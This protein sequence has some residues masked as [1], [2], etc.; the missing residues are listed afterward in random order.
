MQ[1]VDNFLIVNLGGKERHIDWYT[2]Y[3]K[4]DILFFLEAV[5]EY[6]WNWA[7]EAILIT[8][9]VKRLGFHVTNK[10]ANGQAV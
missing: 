2:S 6:V 8:L 7:K 10:S 1:F 5:L 9:H 4:N 3:D